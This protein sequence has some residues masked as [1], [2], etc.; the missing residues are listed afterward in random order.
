[1]KQNINWFDIPALDLDRAIRFYSAVLGATVA[2][3][4]M[5][6]MTIGMLPTTDGPPM[7]CILVDENFKPSANG[8]R[9]YLGVDDRLKAAVAAVRANGGAVQE[10][11]HAI[12]PFGFRANVLDSEGDRFA[13]HSETEA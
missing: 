8:I 13:L 12:G 4:E 10:D 6:D 11:I 9:I 3:Q 7:G 1:M 5:G 2:E